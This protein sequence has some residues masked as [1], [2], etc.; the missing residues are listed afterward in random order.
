MITDLQLLE[1]GILYL[2]MAVVSRHSNLV[3]MLNQ[4]VRLS[5]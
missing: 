1:K 5:R 2:S 4:C 3:L